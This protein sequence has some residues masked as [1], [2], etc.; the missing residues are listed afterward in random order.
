M[1]KKDFAAIALNLGSET[2]VVYVAS[3]CSDALPSSF[4]LELDIHPSRR[5][6]ISGLIAKE[7]PTKIPAE[8][9]NFADVFSPDL[10][11]ELPKHT[12]INNHAI[13]LVNGY[14]QPPYKPIHSLRAVELETLKAY[15]E[16]NLA[17]GFIRSSNF[18]AGAFILF[19]RKSDGSL[20]LCV[21]YQGLNNL[22]VKNRY[23]LPL[24]R[25]LLDRFERAKQ[26]TQLNLTSA[27]HR[28]RIREGDEWKTAFKTW[29]SHFE[30][31]VMLFGLMNT[32]ASF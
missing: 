18:P 30:Y 2:F 31:Q 5:P 26:F 21:N 6:Q 13:E 32:L 20:R 17:N 8:Y 19:D 25:E 16:T 24:I 1:G 7:A 9:S 22:T 4:P 27:Y 10:A 15:S 23:P 29:Y 12:G 3:L 14:Q 11:A 28:M